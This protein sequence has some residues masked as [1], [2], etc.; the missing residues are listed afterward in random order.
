MTWTIRTI[1]PDGVRTV[2]PIAA[3]LLSEAV[4]LTLGRWDM[5]AL[6]EHL[7]D[8]KRTLW[9]IRDEEK[10]VWAVFV[11][12]IALYPR[13]RILSCDFIGGGG[14]SGWLPT[15]SETLDRYVEEQGLDGLELGGRDGWSKPLQRLGWRRFSGYDKLVGR[16]P[17]GA[18]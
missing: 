9:V 17:R 6:Y 8:D 11:T 5:R 7:R 1:P 2:W 12:H 16:S 14:L 10:V 15:L 3:P 18:E 4:G 13:L